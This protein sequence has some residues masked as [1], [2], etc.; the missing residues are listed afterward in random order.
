MKQVNRLQGLLFLLCAVPTLMVARP[1][2]IQYVNTHI[3]TGAFKGRWSPGNEAKGQCMPAVLVPNGMNA[4]TPQTEATERRGVCPFYAPHDNG[5]D[6][7]GGSG[8]Q[9]DVVGQLQG[10]R[11]SHWMNGSNTQDYGSLTIMPMMDS[12]PSSPARRTSAFTMAGMTHRPDYL[13]MDL[14]GGTIKVELTATA[15]TGIFRLTFNKSGRAYILV[16]PNSDYNDAAI[17]GYG[18][19]AQGKQHYTEVSASNQVHRLYQGSGQRAGFAAHYLVLV[20]KTDGVSH[21]R[22]TEGNRQ[23]YYMSFTV[24][25]GEQVLVKVGNSYCDLRGAR[26]NIEQECPH[27]NFDQVRRNLTRIWE[28]RLAAI[29]VSGATD[30][31]KV[32][33]YTSL[34]HASFLPSMFNDVDGRYPSFGGGKHIMHTDGVYYDGY[35]LWDTFRA[36]HPLLSILYPQQSGHMMQ[37]LVDKYRQGGWLPIFPAWNSYTSE[38]IGDPCAS[39]FADAYIKGIRNFDVQTAYEALLK[40]AYE[41]PASFDDYKDGKGRRA[42]TSYIKY[43]YIPLEDPVREAFHQ[44]EQVSRTLE[45]A[46]A[47]YCVA[48]LAEALGHQAVADSLYARSKNYRNVFDPRIGYVM[49]RHADGSFITGKRPDQGQSFITE[50]NPCQY[51][52]FVPHDVYGLFDCMGGRHEYLLRLDSM[53]TAHRMWHGN[54]PSHHIAYLYNYVGKPWLS[55]RRVRHLMDTEYGLGPDGLSGNDDAGQMAAWYIFSALGFYPVCPG[56]GYYVLASPSFGSATLH[57]AS[58]KRFTI[59]AHGASDQNIYIQSARLNGRPYDLNYLS[60]ADIAAG[61]TLVFE[62]GSRP[63]EHWG[64]AQASCP[65]AR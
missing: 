56:S 52:W 8:Q 16:T 35:S 59:V 2:L 30:R 23:L 28:K 61:G 19:V 25:A 38:M 63:N 57:M 49:G 5:G 15:R 62:M 54:E 10:F 18:Q 4:W 22:K 3:G 37:S 20:N 12:V 27:W 46:Y 44:R 58:G 9:G 42:L 13:A 45:Y 6:A 1:S 36:L 26:R 21:V 55:A 29:T 17:E 7:K 41:Q 60:H 40:N 24:K 53:F 32:K 14:Y 47:D 34:Y 33:F 39:L 50:G 48:R 31:D 11:C 51:S 65:P 64:S 43:G